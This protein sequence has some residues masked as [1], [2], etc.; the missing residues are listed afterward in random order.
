M[1]IPFYKTN[2]NSRYK[3]IMFDVGHGDSFLLMNNKKAFLVDCG[4]RQPFHHTD[5]PKKIERILRK[6]NSCAFVLSHYHYDHFS[7]FSM[8]Q[9]PSAIFSKIYV[10]YLCPHGPASHASNFVIKYLILAIISKYSYF[11]V[12]PEIFVRSR[13]PIKMLK[14]GDLIK[15]PHQNFKVF[16]PDLYNIIIFNRKLEHLIK[17][18]NK[19]LEKFFKNLNIEFHD[20][21]TEDDVVNLFQ[22][23]YEIRNM[24]MKEDKKHIIHGNLIELKNIFSRTANLFSLGFTSIYK[25]KDRFLFLGDIPNHV[26]NV[27]SVPGKKSYHSI[28]ASHHGSSFGNSL[29]Y[30]RTNF[31]LIS[32]NQRE[33]PLL[34]PIHPKY[35]RNI[36]YNDMLITEKIGHCIVF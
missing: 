7:L 15:G 16:W 25:R 17:K 14:R 9:N 19:L 23:L 2:H 5:I 1:V 33:F 27:I 11:D 28:K 36:I 29:N 35:F 4:S 34:K 10:P 20:F 8:L 18:Y 26:L 30:I 3:L 21:E 13:R 31:I 32:R 22:H 12:L 24:D 6:D